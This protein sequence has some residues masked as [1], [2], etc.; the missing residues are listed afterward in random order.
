VQQRQQPVDALSRGLAHGRSHRHVELLDE[1]DRVIERVAQSHPSA[2]VDLAR[3]EAE[4]LEG[5][6]VERAPTLPDVGSH[7]LS[8]V[9]GR[10]AK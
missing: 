8:L 5:R 9:H 3:Q 10:H 4:G 6:R 1:L 2:I 7:T